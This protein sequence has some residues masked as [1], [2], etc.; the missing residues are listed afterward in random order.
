MS[1][2]ML[3]FHIIYLQITCITYVMKQNRQDTKKQNNSTMP[4]IKIKIHLQN[5]YVI[6]KI[7]LGQ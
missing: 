1:S 5:T 2:A 3:C 7:Y 4:V 6:G